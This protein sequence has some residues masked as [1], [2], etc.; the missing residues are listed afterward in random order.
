M[1][2]KRRFYNTKRCQSLVFIQNQIS[3]FEFY[4]NSN[5]KYQRFYILK[6]FLTLVIF[7][8]VMSQQNQGRLVGHEILRKLC[9]GIFFK[10]LSIRFVQKFK[11]CVKEC[12]RKQGSL[13]KSAQIGPNWLGCLLSQWILWPYIQD[14]RQIIL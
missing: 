7:D 5:F 3:T 12:F 1:M 4:C 2:H 14:F 6:H 8:F 10:I 9:T 13:A 11:F